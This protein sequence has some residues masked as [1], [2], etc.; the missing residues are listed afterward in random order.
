[1]QRKKSLTTT[2]L[3]QKVIHLQSELSKCRQ[4]IADY[5]NNYHYQLLEELKEKNQVLES[6][7]KLLERSF[8]EVHEEKDRKEKENAELIEK[9]DEVN[10][11]RDALNE[12]LE[13]LKENNKHSD[14]NSEVLSSE[15]ST[16]DNEGVDWFT[17]N[18]QKEAQQR[19]YKKN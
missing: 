3:Q 13:S 11:M 4:K 5:Q 2:Q 6:R 9:L 16:I 14:N 17:R 7:N 1:M 12:E 19:K 15:D 8:K 18:V 10:K